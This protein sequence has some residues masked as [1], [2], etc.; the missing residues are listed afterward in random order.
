[1]QNGAALIDALTTVLRNVTKEETVQ[2]VLALLD[3]IVT[4]ESSPPYLSMQLR[5]QCCNCAVNAVE[6]TLSVVATRHMV[7]ERYCPHADDPGKA[8]LFHEERARV[9]ASDPYAIFLR[10]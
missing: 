10:C 7:A 4:S 1:M 9:N 6:V 2:Y 5:H 8:R 3:N